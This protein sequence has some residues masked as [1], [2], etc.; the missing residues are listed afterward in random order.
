MKGL[1]YLKK[2][3]TIDFESL[4]I[5]FKPFSKIGIDCRFRIFCINLAF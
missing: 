1:E 4:A 2:L 3:V 5:P